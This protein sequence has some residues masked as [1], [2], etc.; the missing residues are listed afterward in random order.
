V[1]PIAQCLDEA[2][3]EEAHFLCGECAH[4]SDARALRPPEWFNLASLHGSITYRLEED[5]YDLDG[6][7]LQS[8]EPVL[9]ASLHSAPSLDQVRD[10]VEH[11]VD[12]AMARGVLDDEL[13]DALSM[14]DKTSDFQ[15]LQARTQPA[16]KPDILRVAC[17]LYDQCIGP[18]AQDWVR[19]QWNE[20]PKSTIVMAAFIRAARHCLPRDEAYER[21]LGFF[22]RMRVGD[23]GEEVH[24][25]GILQDSR[26]V[27][28]IEAGRSVW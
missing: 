24:P 9:D 12:Y 7:A 14:L 19:Q 8:I 16:K 17:E 18:L 28:W 13:I 25:L 23:H 21:A 20:W 1:R 6:A 2:G 27:D 26:V 3:D 5:F 4:R 22:G 10:K 11:L 15:A